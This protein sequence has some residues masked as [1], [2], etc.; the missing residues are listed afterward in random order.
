M[1]WIKSLLESFLNMVVDLLP[2]SPFNFFSADFA[3]SD[4]VKTMQMIKW[5]IPVDTIVLITGAWIS[6]VAVYYVYS[7]IL[8]TINAVD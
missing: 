8:R 3:T 7:V 6:C 2:D 1:E 5:F 4:F